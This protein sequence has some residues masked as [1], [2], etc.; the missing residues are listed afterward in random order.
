MT[1]PLR[2]LLCA[3]AA[4]TAAGCSHATT[5]TSATTTTTTTSGGATTFAVA[6]NFTVRG[7]ASRSFESTVAGDIAVTLTDVNPDVPLGLGVGI[8]RPDGTGCSLTRAATVRLGTTPQ[9]TIAADPGNW[10]VRVW[11]L[12]FVSERVAFALEVSHY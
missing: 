9:I 5:P 3:V 7:S 11:D 6:S 12:G 4:A 2:L 8:P 10:C 1:R